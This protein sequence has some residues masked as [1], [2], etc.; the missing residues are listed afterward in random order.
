M[1][2]KK[3]HLIASWLFYCWCGKTYYFT[4]MV[5]PLYIVQSFSSFIMVFLYQTLQYVKVRLGKK[6]IFNVILAR[7]GVESNF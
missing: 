5:A 6:L 7:I 1:P 3:M 2:L 4:I